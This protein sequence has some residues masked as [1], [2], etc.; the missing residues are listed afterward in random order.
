MVTEP[1]PSLA[2]ASDVPRL[3]RPDPRDEGAL[4]SALEE[5]DRGEG[6]LMT[7]EVAERAIVT[8]QWP[9]SSE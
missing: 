4:R 2:R 3:V 8:G 7:A 5:A 9:D 1:A 6:V